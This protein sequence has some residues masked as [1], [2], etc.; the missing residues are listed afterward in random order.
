M[1]ACG[2]LWNLY[3]IRME[4]NGIKQTFGE[5]TAIARDRGGGLKRYYSCPTDY[6]VIIG[7]DGEGSR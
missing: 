1:C 7:T 3:P 4:W 2:D 6:V 5:Q